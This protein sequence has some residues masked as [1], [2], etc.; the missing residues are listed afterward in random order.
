MNEFTTIKLLFSIIIPLIVFGGIF[1]TI[2]RLLAK[3]KNHCKYIEIINKAMWKN[4]RPLLQSIQESKELRI[5]YNKKHDKIMEKLDEMDEK[6]DKTNTKRDEQIGEIKLHMQ[7]ID[8][9]YIETH[10]G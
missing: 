5:E 4:G 1:I 8:L 6:Q 9:W 7:K 10:K 3:Q 2:G